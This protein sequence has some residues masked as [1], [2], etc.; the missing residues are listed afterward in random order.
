MGRE[1]EA[2]E[3]EV[4]K[5]GMGLMRRKYERREGTKETD[6]GKYRTKEEKESLGEVSHKKWSSLIH[7]V[8]RVLWRHLVITG[9]SGK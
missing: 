8:L 4:R 1:R 2:G 7:A 5:S 3:R 6:A 9:Y